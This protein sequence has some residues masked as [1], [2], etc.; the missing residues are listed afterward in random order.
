MLAPGRCGRVARDRIMALLAENKL[1]P[2]LDADLQ[3]VIQALSDDDLATLARTDSAFLS[4]GFRASN[5]SG[6]RVRAFQ[7]ATGPHLISDSFRRMLARHSLNHSLI[8]LLSTAALVD[9]RHDLAVLFGPSRVLLGALLDE[10]QEVREIADRWLHQ[11]KTPATSN[12]E[13]A[14]SHLRE[15]FARL[16]EAMGAVGANA[17]I[18]R[19]TWQD[20]RQQ[21]EQQLRDARAETRKLKGVEERLA[22][23]RDQ[24][25]AQERELTQVRTRVSETETLLRQTTRERD[26][27]RTELDREL[28]HR[29]ERLLAAVEARLA[30]EAVGWL[31]GAHAV[32]VEATAQNS[33]PGQED[34][35]VRAEAAL[36][37]Q[38][39]A[40]R[41]SG[42]R[43]QLIARLGTLESRLA[44][45]RDALANAL[46]PLP[47]LAEIERLLAAETDRLTRLLRR[48]G[49]RSSLEATLSAR[50]ATA[51][52]NDLPALR[53]LS[54]RLV[55]LGGIS[56]EA[57]ARLIEALQRRQGLIH[58]TALPSAKG[59]EPSDPTAIRLLKH[60]LSGKSAAVLLIDGHN[61]LFGLQGRYMPPQ[62]AAVP[63]A[64][65]R[66]RLVQD[67]VR[68]TGDRPTCRAWIV[69]DGPSR[70][71]STAAS[72][73][74]VTYSGGEGEHRA[75]TALLDNVRFF[76]GTSGIPVILVSNDMS[77]GVETRRLGAATL[78]AADL[79][80]FL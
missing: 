46:H 10:R 39:S 45:T 54:D 25:A 49:E 15:R 16:T 74:R 40:D 2:D 75:D 69:F 23:A 63:T 13:Q 65:A 11:D 9:L 56:A 59:E 28:R 58:T 61:V 77:L 78:S 33:A 6:L 44:E 22:R 62:G 24:L 68:L 71:E 12:P 38:A 72:N 53:S 7:M 3:H 31:A 14:A 60:A 35:V 29:E 79:A 37:R 52:P 18:T 20:A 76:K 51:E 70:S 8:A 80:A 19:E 43:V 55:A 42:N 50:F 67:I 26:A 47:E 30:E 73:V 4:G 41:H 66:E 64:A 36:I 57:G 27:T 5:T 17:P 1:A 34:I 48:D 21:L 32:A